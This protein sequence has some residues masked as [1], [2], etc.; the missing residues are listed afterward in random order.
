M[1]T[2]VDEHRVHKEEL[3]A[4]TEGRGGDTEAWLKIMSE[5]EEDQEQPVGERVGSMN[6]Y[7]MPKGGTFS[8]VLL[9][10]ELRD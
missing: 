10:G 8:L 5:W 6:P 2:A 1:K 7:E 3:K 9:L 4:F